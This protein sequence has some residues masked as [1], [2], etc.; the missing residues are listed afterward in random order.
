MSRTSPYFTKQ[1]KYHD[2]A[3]TLQYTNTQPY[4]NN[5]EDLHS[6]ILHP[7]SYYQ[8]HHTKCG[9]EEEIELESIDVEKRKAR[10][11]V[12]EEEN[13]SKVRYSD[14]I[15][16]IHIKPKSCNS[17]NKDNT[18]PTMNNT[19]NI[20]SII[21][22]NINNTLHTE[23]NSSMDIEDELMNSS[24]HTFETLNNNDNNYNNNINNMVQIDEGDAWT[25]GYTQ[26]VLFQKE[27]AHC[28]V[29]PKHNTFMLYQW[30]KEQGIAHKKRLLDKEKVDLLKNIGFQW[31]GLTQHEK[32]EVWFDKFVAFMKD[33]QTDIELKDILK[34]DSKLYQ[35]IQRQIRKKK[36]G[37]LEQEKIDKL[38]SVGFFWK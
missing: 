23:F 11:D 2:I 19:H 37:K 24:T 1:R 17:Q 28:K 22:S 32:W 10:D 30:C 5:N 16:R 14:N 15:L 21:L 6:Q 38:D 26:L 25:R 33:L 3:R 7:H 4:T 20:E 13:E 31:S 9:E 29:M 8:R 35:W 27:Y 36:E 34:L 12:G 18:P